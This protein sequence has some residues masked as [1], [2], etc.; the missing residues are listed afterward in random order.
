MSWDVLLTP[1]ADGT[2]SA[3]EEPEGR[4]PHAV[5]AP[6]AA[7][8]GTVTLGTVAEVGAAIRAAVPAVDLT[9]PAWGS[10]VGPQWSMELAIGETEPVPAVLLHLRGTGDDAVAYVH[11]LAAALGCLPVEAGQESP[12]PPGEAGV[13]RWQAYQR[14]RDNARPRRR[15][16]V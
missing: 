13:A 12:V 4:T 11:R 15:V 2:T 6:G 1:P 3:G 9:D 10:L 16:G 7:V 5:P 14:E 8:L